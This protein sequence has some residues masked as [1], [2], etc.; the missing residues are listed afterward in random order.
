MGPTLVLLWE[1]AALCQ[2]ESVPC[3]ILHGIREIFNLWIC[4]MASATCPLISI[5][6]HVTRCPWLDL[7]GKCKPWDSER[8]FCGRRGSCDVEQSL[9]A[10]P[11]LRSDFW[12]VARGDSTES[13]AGFYKHETFYGD[14]TLPAW[15]EIKNKRALTSGPI[16]TSTSFLQARF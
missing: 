15:Q 9:F 2:R 6:L 12:E 10:I 14:G 7:V 8:E 4:C 3:N 11:W 13:L 5:T 16:L 1:K